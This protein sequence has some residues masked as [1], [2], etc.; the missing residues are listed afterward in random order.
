MIIFNC[1]FCHLCLKSSRKFN[2]FNVYKQ[3]NHTNVPSF[4]FYIHSQYNVVIVF[5]T[6]LN[7]MIFEETSNIIFCYLFEVT[8]LYHQDQNVFS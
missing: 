4:V 2:Y 1:F 6:L 5:I 8:K 7:Y 3:S